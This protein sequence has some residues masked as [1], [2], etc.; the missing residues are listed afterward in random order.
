M[1]RIVY[2][3]LVAVGAIGV[4][5]GSMGASD[6]IDTKPAVTAACEMKCPISSCEM[7]NRR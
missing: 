1:R 3:A 5:A 6:Y 7:P 2:M 4:A